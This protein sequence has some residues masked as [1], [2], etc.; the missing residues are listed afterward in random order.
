MSIKKYKAKGYLNF[1]YTP[2]GLITQTWTRE[3]LIKYNT[4]HHEQDEKF[5]ESI[6][7]WVD[8]KLTITDY[9]LMTG[10]EFL[11]AV[12]S[13]S[14]MDYDGTLSEILADGYIT[15]LGLVHKG[16]QQGDFLV[17]ADAFKELCN[18]YDI[19]VNWANK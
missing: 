17:N 5:K 2:D 8:S 14:I 15:N 13:G 19:K 6:T 18:E 16:L 3:D 7:E 1:C 9:D 12:D 10:Q 4:R 11:E